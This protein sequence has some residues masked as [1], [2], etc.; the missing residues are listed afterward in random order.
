VGIILRRSGFNHELTR[1]V[2]TSTLA[3]IVDANQGRSATAVATN[4]AFRG[5]LAF[6]A[7]EIAVPMQV[8]H[9]IISSE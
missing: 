6:I 7:T 3:Y 8:C 9:M 4:S 1:W 5:T 2:Y